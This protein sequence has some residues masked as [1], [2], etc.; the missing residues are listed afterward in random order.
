MSTPEQLA[1]VVPLQTKRK[2]WAGGFVNLAN[3][4]PKEDEENTEKLELVN[5]QLVKKL[6]TRKITNKDDWTTAFIRY[7]AVYLDKTPKRMWLYCVI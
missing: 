1:F 4:L 5:G 6:N 3:F 2:I 7:M